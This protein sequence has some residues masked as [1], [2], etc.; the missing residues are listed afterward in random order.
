MGLSA[1][2]PQVP[3]WQPK[4][5]ASGEVVEGL[6]DIAQSIQIILT[7][8]QGQSPLRPTFGCLLQDLL[9]DPLTVSKPGVVREVSRAL[10]LWE[11]RITVSQVGLVDSGDGILGVQVLWKLVGGQDLY[12][13]LVDLQTPLMVTV[14][15]PATSGLGV[16]LV[17]SATGPAGSTWFWTI[18]NGSILGGQ[19]TA[20]INYEPTGAGLVTVTATATPPTGGPL[21]GSA[22]TMAFAAPGI[23][24][25]A[26]EY[27]WAGQ[28]GVQASIGAQ[29][30][31]TVIAWSGANI[32]TDTPTNQTTFTFDAGQ[33]GPSTT[34]QAVVTNPG[35]TAT[36]SA[37]LKVV[38]YTS[39]I[40]HTTAALAD[41]NFE[42]FQIDMGWR[43]ELLAVG[44]DAPACIRI[45]ET[46]A[47]RT[48]DAGR[49]LVTDPVVD[50]TNQTAIVFEGHTITGTLSFNLE[51]P[52]V[53]TN[54]DTPRTK[55]AY[56]RIFNTSGSSASITL[57]LTRSELQIGPT[58]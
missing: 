53:G 54:G 15:A 40:Q 43:Y 41:T 28:F 10:A 21:V 5:A 58:F 44:T 25:T 24:I 19:G 57:T 2:I 30:A 33:A 16:P 11:P 14:T 56:C 49:D 18:T 42:D 45:Y 52:V 55:A 37:T 29:P 26:P 22:S 7:T 23:A 48:A 27:V 32:D 35:G 46:A 17:A 36:A 9:D 12:T 47:A 6:E 13:S 20:S 51:H 3:Y 39:Q 34:V 8:R 31:G 38:P 50:P 1:A 4:L